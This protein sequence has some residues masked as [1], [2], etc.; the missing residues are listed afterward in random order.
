MYVC[1]MMRDS[2]VNNHMQLC[3]YPFMVSIQVND[4]AV[5]N[6]FTHRC[7]GSLVAPRWILTA[8]HCVTPF[9]NNTQVVSVLIGAL[10]VTNNGYTR[11]LD[12]GAEF[13]HVSGAVYHES[14]KVLTSGAVVNDIALLR[15]PVASMFT[16]KS[17]TT[18]VRNT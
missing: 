1:V 13:M 15:L 18:E 4:S 14:Y 6:T 17:I 10:N 16:P 11:S 12:P 8:A 3:R 9:V 7:G 5:S 2:S